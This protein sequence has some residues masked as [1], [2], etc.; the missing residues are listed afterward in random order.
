[1]TIRLLPLSSIQGKGIPPTAFPEKGAD[2]V[3]VLNPS[4][5]ERQSA[6]GELQMFVSECCNSHPNS[7]Y[8]VSQLSVDDHG[9]TTSLSSTNHE[10]SFNGRVEILIPRQ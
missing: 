6:N 3:L 1:M 8:E 10:T 9:L 5:C 4:F 7:N 2:K